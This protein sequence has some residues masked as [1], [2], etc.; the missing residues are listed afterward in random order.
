M[1]PT[2]PSQFGFSFSLMAVA[3]PETPARDPNPDAPSDVACSPNA[4]DAADT[5]SPTFWGFQWRAAMEWSQW[6][7]FVQPAWERWVDG[8]MNEIQDRAA[9]QAV[10]RRADEQQLT[11]RHRRDES[12]ERAAES[13]NLARRAQEPGCDSA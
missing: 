6:S 12:A 1:I 2:L 10:E 11:L 9:R 3:R 8:D 13:T 4:A 7:P 5:Q